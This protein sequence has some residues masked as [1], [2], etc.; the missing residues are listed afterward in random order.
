MQIILLILVINYC[1]GQNGGSQRH[2]VPLPRTC[3]YYLIWQI[4]VGAV[5]DAATRRWS[6]IIQVDP[7]C[8]HTCP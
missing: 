1:R 3:N 5:K 6:R 7:N 8:H 4:L 2:Q